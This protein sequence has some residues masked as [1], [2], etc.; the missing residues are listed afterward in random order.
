MPQTPPRPR[1]KGAAPDDA[2]LA[3][4]LAAYEGSDAEYTQY[5]EAD[6]EDLGPP[7]TLAEALAAL[8]AAGTGETER[9]GRRAF[10]VAGVLIDDM[11]WLWRTQATVPERVALAA[12]LWQSGMHEAM[13]AAAKLLTQARL[14]PDDGAWDLILTWVPD[15]TGVATAEAAC[16][17]A[18]RRLSAD[19]ARLAQVAAWVEAPNPWTRRAAL[20]SALPFAKLN[21]PD[22]AET[23]ARQEVLGWCARLAR[24]PDPRVTKAV[25]Q[26]LRVLAK[27][28][29]DRVQ[30][31][32]ASQESLPKGLHKAVGL[33][34]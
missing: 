28:D 23:Q 32:L 31:W 16:S 11:A 19:P 26:W 20:I 4:E 3:A 9:E 7:P 24:D 1:Q 17:A 13:L 21:H 6:D 25:T 2:Q 27:H 14:R 33:G 30:G 15:L 18:A 22:P 34:G 5:R 10:G 29:A 8:A 12:G